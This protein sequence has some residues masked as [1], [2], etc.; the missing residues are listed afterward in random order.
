MQGRVSAQRRGRDSSSSNS[1]ARS[2]WRHTSLTHIHCTPPPSFLLCA[3]Y[4]K[5]KVDLERS[6]W[7]AEAGEEFEDSLGNVLDKKTYNDLLK[8]GLL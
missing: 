1:S 8:Q 3:V 5:L 2:L 6:N 7:K 4:A